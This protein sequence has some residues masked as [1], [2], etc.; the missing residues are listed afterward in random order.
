[1]LVFILS[2]SIRPVLSK[3]VDP[4]YAGTIDGAAGSA[5]KDGTSPA[6]GRCRLMRFQSMLFKVGNYHTICSVNSHTIL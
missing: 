1:M 5:K 3:K 6:Q 2:V 4:T